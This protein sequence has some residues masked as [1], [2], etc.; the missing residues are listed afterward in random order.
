MVVEPTYTP[1]AYSGEANCFVPGL[2]A[3]SD[4]VRTTMTRKLKA[5]DNRLYLRNFQA[6]LANAAT[7]ARSIRAPRL[8]ST[9]APNSSSS[10][11][12]KATLLTRFTQRKEIE[13]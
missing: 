9:S 11:N 6:G 8:S 7:C 5:G 3:F 4:R 12:T 13:P 1:A 10:P 2:D